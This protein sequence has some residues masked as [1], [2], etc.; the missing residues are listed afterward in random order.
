VLTVDENEVMDR[1]AV[2][3]RTFSNAADYRCL[4]SGR[5]CDA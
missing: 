5:F 3:E 1:C 2:L 4:E